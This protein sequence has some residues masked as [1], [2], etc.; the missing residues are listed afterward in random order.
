MK[1]GTRRGVGG[2]T[3]LGWLAAIAGA[4]AGFW[5]I[6]L[7]FGQLGRMATEGLAGY[8]GRADGLALAGLVVCGLLWRLAKAQVRR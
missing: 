2:G 4:V 5:S 6:G 1:R 7:S 3:G 8:D